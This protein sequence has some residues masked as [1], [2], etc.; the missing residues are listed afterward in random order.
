MTLCDNILLNLTPVPTYKN[1]LDL[2]NLWAFPFQAFVFGH[3][4]MVLNS[5]ALLA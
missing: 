5:V 4:Q 2:Q 3:N 1:K